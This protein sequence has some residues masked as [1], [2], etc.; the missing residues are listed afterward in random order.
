MTFDELE[1]DA[2]ITRQGNE[3]AL[4][5][6]DAKPMTDAQIKAMKKETAKNQLLIDLRLRLKLTDTTANNTIIDDIADKYEDSLTRALMYLQLYYFYY[7]V[8]QG[9]G[10]LSNYR[11]EKNK[12]AYEAIEAN[13]TSFEVESKSF[14]AFVGMERG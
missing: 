3:D 5:N 14:S 13:F 2:T 9:E 4:R 11:M 12:L 8:N 1:I 6:D 7:E 10:S